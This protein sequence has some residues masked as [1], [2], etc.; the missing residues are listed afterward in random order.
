MRLSPAVIE[1]F[2]GSFLGVWEGTHEGRTGFWLRWWD[3]QGNILLFSEERASEERQ[4]AQQAETLLEQERLRSLA[5]AAR[6]RAMGID[7]DQL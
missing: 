6:L 1:C 2:H 5:L 7:P 3:A 4:R